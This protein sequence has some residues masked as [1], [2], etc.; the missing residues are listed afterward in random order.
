MKISIF[1]TSYVGLVTGACL[2]NLGHQVL[3]IDIDTAK[4][5]TLQEGQIPFYEPGLEELTIRNKSRLHFSS[6]IDEGVAF[7]EVIFNCVG[8]PSNDDGSANLEY[9]FSVV[10]AAAR[11]DSKK[12]LVI[13]STVPPGTARKCQQM[14]KE[15]NPAANIDIVSNPEFLREGL[16]IRAF[17]YP[18]KIV[19]GAANDQAFHLMR[20]VYSG[21]LRTYLP[22]VETDLETAELIKYA[23]NSFLS[24]KISF[25]NEIA[26]ICDRTGADVK[27]V[28]MALGMDYRISP[29]FLNPGV[30]YG[31]SCFPKDVKALAHTAKEVGYRARLFEEVMALNDRQKSVLVEKVLAASNNDITG[32]TFCVW[33]LAF[34]PNTSDMREAPAIT[35]I[36]ELLKHGARIRAYDPKAVEEAK[37]FFGDSITYCATAE[38]AAQDSDGILVITEWDEFRNVNLSE[39]KMKTKRI[40]DGRNI[41][42]PELV[43]EEGFQYHGMGRR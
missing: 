11:S 42:E 34:K 36:S 29:R 17:N 25:I 7:G 38:E 4:I 8:T 9:V 37:H 26:N 23:N 6:N 32:K 14:I 16:A 10:K 35:I 28:A 20:K 40:F 27:M 21:R 5:K 3:C 2:A 22:V 19:V 41:Y 15:I 18:D 24:T 1:G 31:G 33:G 43:K 30:G 39:L 12:L 13:K